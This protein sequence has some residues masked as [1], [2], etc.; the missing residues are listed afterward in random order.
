[1]AKQQRRTRTAKRQQGN[2]QTKP[3]GNANA[4]PNLVGNTGVPLSQ[5]DKDIKEIAKNV[6]M[7]TATLK[8]AIKTVCAVLREKKD[9]CTIR[10]L[11][12]KLREKALAHDVSDAVAALMLAEKTTY[13]GDRSRT[14]IMVNKELQ[15]FIGESLGKSLQNKQDCTV[16]GLQ[17]KAEGLGFSP[18]DFRAALNRQIN[19]GRVYIDE[20]RNIKSDYIYT[21]PGETRPFQRPL[22]KTKSERYYEEASP[23]TYVFRNEFAKDHE[24][25]V[26]SSAFRRLAGVTQVFGTSAGHVFHNR[27]THSIKAAQIARSIAERLNQNPREVDDVHPDV[28]EAAALA[29]EPR[30]SAIWP[31]GRVGT[32]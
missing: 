17:K 8:R 11:R 16:D 4:P 27:L 24:R 15:S 5:E 29:H 21:P 10:E 9:G 32:R 26:Y 23:S 6:P 13:T 14:V 1:M 25:I 30:P 31:H 19:R 22:P 2:D 7:A 3:G 28:V 18:D 12:E 20:D